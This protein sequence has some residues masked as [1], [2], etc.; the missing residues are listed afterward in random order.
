MA[1]DIHRRHDCAHPLPISVVDGACSDHALV[2]AVLG[3]LVREIAHELDES[4]LPVVDR[5]SSHDELGEIIEE[6]IAC[7]WNDSLFVRDR[8]VLL[9]HP[10]FRSHWRIRS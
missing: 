6:V 5:S 9:V 8:G 1:D 4:R 7:Q 3:L 2:Q 10:Q